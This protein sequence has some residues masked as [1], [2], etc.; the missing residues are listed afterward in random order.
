MNRIIIIG[1][2]AAGMAA[3]IRAAQV[4]PTAQITILERLDRVGKKI[5]ATGNGRCNLTNEMILP[6]HYHTQEPERLENLLS[7]MPYTRTVDFFQSIGLYCTTEDM[8]RMY[9]YCKQ[10]SMTLDVLLLAL[11]RYKIR[12]VCSSHVVDISTRN[13]TFSVKTEDGTIYHADA[14]I[15]T[16]GGRAAPKQ[17]TNGSAYPLAVKMGHSY[18]RLYPCLVPIQCKNNALK[19]L[20][21]IRMTC[22]AV[23]YRGKQQLTEELGEIQLTEYGLSGIPALQLSCLLHIPPKETQYTIRLDLFPDWSYQELRSL[24]QQRVRQYPD[25]PLEYLLLG[26]IHKRVMYAICKALALEPLSRPASSL[27]KQEIDR[28]VSTLKGWKFPVTGTLSW[29]QA[30]V[31]GGGVFL[32]EIADDFA[33]R[34]QRGLYLA[35]EILDVAGDCGGYNLHWAWCSGMAAG[36][37]AAEYVSH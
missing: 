26:L 33:S 32:H 36:A 20:K 9:P 3:A 17:G 19:G 34:R 4:N 37:A 24:L 13:H 25:A 29:E 2:G 1:G 5:L 16:A 11:K 10:A 28:L 22:Q 21:G 35:G 7:A 15:L 23:L 14:V 18:A 27:S 8:G 12:T 6:E 30:Q 31:T